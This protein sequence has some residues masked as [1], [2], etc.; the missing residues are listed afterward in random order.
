MR[1]R[2]PRPRSTQRA[3]SATRAATP[4]TA[5][6]VSAGEGTRERLP[7]HH[8]ERREENER[9][10]RDELVLRC[11]QPGR[12][13]RG[14]C[15]R[16]R[17][18]TKSDQGPQPARREEVQM[19]ADGRDP[20]G[21]RPKRG[22]V[23]LGGADQRREQDQGSSAPEKAPTTSQSI[24]RGGTNG[25]PRRRRGGSAGAPRSSGCPTAAARLSHTPRCD[26]PARSA[27]RGDCQQRNADAAKPST[28]AYA[29]ASY[30]VVV[31]R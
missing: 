21:P 14:P 8:A 13:R 23:I 1:R 9:S 2:R 16:R 19:E 11:R 26:P 28:K 20:C 17:K 29:R 12:A 6:S 10:E 31:G 24:S 5:A 18:H 15:G 4:I 3:A 30:A 22:G 7:Y 25:R 27:L